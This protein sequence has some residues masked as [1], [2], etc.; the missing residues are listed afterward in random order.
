[1]QVFAEFV[2]AK[3]DRSRAR[4]AKRSDRLG[5]VHEVAEA[6]PIELIASDEVE[7][8]APPIALHIVYR[9]ASGSVSRRPITLRKIVFVGD[10]LRVYGFC[11]VRR[12]IRCFL[13]SRIAEVIDMATGEV[14]DDAR[15]YFAA[16][17]L[18]EVAEPRSAS[19]DAVLECQHEIVV[20]MFVAACDFSIVDEEVD[21][22]VL[23]VM[24]AVPDPDVQEDEV[25]R[26]IAGLVLDEAAF[27]RALNALGN[28]KGNA[29]RLWRSVRK[30]IDADE[31]DS[32][33]REVEPVRRAREVLNG[34]AYA[35]HGGFMSHRSRRVVP[36]SQTQFGGIFA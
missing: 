33:G 34:N 26:C 18:L 5:L 16:H 23:H 19:A 29:K 21:E 4:V 36:N 3:A 13:A 9:A 10:D 20:L 1:M 15:A 6:D 14:H 32:V 24:N 35:A 31:P 30:V 22:V 28:G 8:D 27:N 25:R 2:G 7:A 17:P 11:H 12:A